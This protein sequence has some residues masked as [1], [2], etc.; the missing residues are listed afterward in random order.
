MENVREMP[1]KK[2]PREKSKSIYD[3]LEEAGR[4]EAIDKPIFARNLGRLA[5]RISPDKPLDG[6]RLIVRHAGNDNLWPTKR[7]K[8]FRFS[9]EEVPPATKGQEYASSPRQFLRLAEAAGRLLCKAQ[10][11]KALEKSQFSA[12][13]TLLAGSSFVADR[14]PLDTA[15]SSAKEL[16]DEYRRALSAAIQSRTQIVK[17]WETLDR[18]SIGIR[19]D[20]GYTSPFGE[21]AVVPWGPEGA[22][23]DPD[24]Y[25]FDGSI[26]MDIGWVLITLDINPF[27]IPED[28]Q[29]LFRDLNRYAS[30]EA[31]K[32]M[33]SVGFDFK[34]NVFPTPTELNPFTAH[35]FLPVAIRV[36]KSYDMTPEIG[37]TIGKRRIFYTKKYCGNEELYSAIKNHNDC[38]QSLYFNCE[39]VSWTDFRVIYDKPIIRPFPEKIMEANPVGILPSGWGYPIDDLYYDDEENRVNIESVFIK[40]RDHYIFDD[41]EALA[42][43]GRGWTETPSVADFLLG[44]PAN[45]ELDFG[46]RRI[47]VGANFLPSLPDA[48]PVGGVMKAG[49]IGASLLHNARYAAPE[50]RL[51]DKIIDKA[52][53]IAKAGLR[54]YQ[55]MIEDARDAVARI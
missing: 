55:A 30:D 23:F 42:A 50:N 43:E 1:V 25:D 21:A 11:P 6:A 32:W 16:L 12:V 27:P 20:D 46:T 26:I 28:K 24:E 18:S 38:T 19:H 41:L 15:I 37:I 53:L 33:E 14:A 22:F 9:N 48:E 36:D 5:E 52:D 2:H 35:V 13:E 51:T 47:A 34:E 29:Y 4:L 39:K 54:F 8:Y 10:D 7:K 31:I 17:L 40:A 3:R 44:C 49:S 45:Q